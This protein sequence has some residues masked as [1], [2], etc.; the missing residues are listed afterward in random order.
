[1]RMPEEEACLPACLPCR[2]RR[3]RLLRLRLRIH[4]I[5]SCSSRYLLR[6]GLRKCW[7]GAGDFCRVASNIGLSCARE[8]EKENRTDLDL[9]FLLHRRPGKLLF[10]F[11]TL[12]ILRA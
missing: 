4:L 5:H 11:W 12:H 6:P 1:M 10:A 8:H 3:S 2:C 9:D 7:T